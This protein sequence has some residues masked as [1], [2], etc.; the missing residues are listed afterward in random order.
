LP[1]RESLGAAARAKPL[2]R[3]ISAGEGGK[4]EGD[5]THVFFSRGWDVGESLGSFRTTLL[6]TDG[7]DPRAQLRGMEGGISPRCPLCTYRK[8]FKPQIFPPEWRFVSLSAV[9]SRTGSG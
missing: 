1:K 3:G 5:T 7:L 4:A 9:I 2:Q 6:A 8:H